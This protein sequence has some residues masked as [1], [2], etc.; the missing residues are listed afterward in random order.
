VQR[1]SGFLTERQLRRVGGH[2][3]LLLVVFLIAF[4][5]LF[6]PFVHGMDPVGYYSWLRSALID[7]D[8]DTSNEYEHYGKAQVGSSTSTGH[9]DNPYA[10]GS[11]L[12]WAPFFFS[13]HALVL[14]MQ[15]IGSS[16][17][18]DGYAAPYTFA[19]SCAS[20]LYAWTAVVLTYRLAR[21]LFNTQSALLAVLLA[22]LASPLVF[23][24]YAHPMMAHAN[25]AFAYALLLW[26]WCSLQKQ[27][28]ATHYALV[29]AAAGLCALVRNQNAL[30]AVIP[31]VDIGW[32]AIQM[33]PASTGWQTVVRSTLI[34]VGAFSAAWWLTFAPQLVTWKLVFGVWWPGNPYASSGGGEFDWLHPHILG[35][36]LSTDRGLLVW[37]PALALA[38]IGWVGLWK[39][40]RRLAAFIVTSFALQLYVIAAWS[41]WSGAAAFG[42]RFFTNLIPGFGLGLAALVT[43]AQERVRWRWLVAGS[44][45]FV[46]WNGLLMLRYALNDVPHAGT[47][48][49]DHLVFGQIEFLLRHAHRVSDLLLGR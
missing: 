46:A 35:V 36:L 15:R 24:Q 42:Q 17:P 25:D 26:A 49:L 29:G 14:V 28:D 19:V 30:F 21:Q 5:I 7:G 6:R 3:V 27:R 22:W 39:R 48:S 40:H 13:A 34:A 2:W 8:L 31:L 20:A 23:Y 33:H 47:V 37:T 16:W 38:A 45:V 11:A 10:I 32:R 12:L 44:V 1:Q 18:A 9:R 43:R 41:A 4:P